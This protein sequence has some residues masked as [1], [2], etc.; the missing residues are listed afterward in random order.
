MQEKTV[1][2]MFIISVVAIL[3]VVAWIM[4]FNGTVFAFTS[5]IIGLS[6]GAVLGFKFSHTSK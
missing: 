5:L 2:A 6:A 4:G 1:F 3:Q